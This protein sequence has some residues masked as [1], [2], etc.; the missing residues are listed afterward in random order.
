MGHELSRYLVGEMFLQGGR[1]DK[2][3]QFWRPIAEGG[4]P[5]APWVTSIRERI[6]AVAGLAGVGYVLPEG[7]ERGPSAADIAAAGEMS[8]EDRQAMIE[9]MV[10]Q[11]ADRPAFAGQPVEDWNRLIRSLVELE[12]LDEAQGIYNEAKVRFAGR[13]AELSFLRLAAV[14][15]GLTP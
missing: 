10:A 11:L 6:E 9:G 1:Y 15:T 12:R 8:P 14:E 13:P 2:A 5:A 3:F 4:N 7:L